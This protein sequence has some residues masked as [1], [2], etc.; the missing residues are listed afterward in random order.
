MAMHG[1]LDNGKEGVHMLLWQEMTLETR[2]DKRRLMHIRCMPSF[3]P[4]P[5][6]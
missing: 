6:V 4:T 2:L 3:L 1:W 5:I